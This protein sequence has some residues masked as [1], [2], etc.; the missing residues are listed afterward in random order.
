MKWW[1]LL[2]LVAE[3]VL[4]FGLGLCLGFGIQGLA[5]CWLVNGQRFKCGWIKPAKRKK[6]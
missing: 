6:R 5:N 1:T 3:F 4:G 2:G